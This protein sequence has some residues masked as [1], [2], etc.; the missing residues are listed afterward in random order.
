MTIQISNP[1]DDA[2]EVC[3]APDYDNCN[4]R[5]AWTACDTSG[6]E[7]CT[8]TLTTDI[9]M[10]SILGSVNLQ[11][12]L[13]YTVI[14]NSYTVFSKAENTLFSRICNPCNDRPTLNLLDTI[15]E[16]SLQRKGKKELKVVVLLMEIA[17]SY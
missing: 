12:G 2:N 15:L 13:V 5:A 9:T 4:L 6:D 1:V 14:G 7:D 10:S 3:L 11:E 8:L 17:T 16:D